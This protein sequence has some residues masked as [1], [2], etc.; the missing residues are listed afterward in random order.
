MKVPHIYRIPDLCSRLC[1]AASW[2]GTPRDIQAAGRLV[3]QIECPWFR[4]RPFDATLSRQVNQSWLVRVSLSFRRG[5]G[6]VPGRESVP[7]PG[8]I[9]LS[10]PSV[11]RSPCHQNGARH[12]A[13]LP[14]VG[15]GWQSPAEPAC[16][17]G[18][19]FYIAEPWEL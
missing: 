4:D 17:R 18:I 3:I 11:G 14:R 15:S 6:E 13:F 2:D 1:D 16:D 9:A 8:P 19:E 10:R 7:D 5:L 12:L